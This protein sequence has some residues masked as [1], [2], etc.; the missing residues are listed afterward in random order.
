VHSVRAA[1]TA[2]RKEGRQVVC[3]KDDGGITHYRLAAE[4]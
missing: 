3:G 1:L 4:A 2:L